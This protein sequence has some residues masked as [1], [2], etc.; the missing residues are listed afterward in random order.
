MSQTLT[1]LASLAQMVEAV[2]AIVIFAYASVVA[3]EFR[4]SIKTRYLDGMKYVR[5]LIATPEAGEK[6]DWVYN[7][8]GNVT[9]PL[10]REDAD[11]VRA[12][13]RDFDFIGLLCRK[14][15]LP[16]EIITETYSRNILEMWDRL[17]PSVEELRQTAH[18][19]YYYLEFEWLALKA[20][21]AR[22]VV[23]RK[24]PADWL[25]DWTEESVIH[26]LI[27]RIAGFKNR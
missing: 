17:R 25:R 13:C 9:R 24:S 22:G 1:D 2:I 3:R 6:R 11:R 5:D 23:A 27:R 20:A 4:E 26:V 12:I 16:T 19:P 8:L 18:D 15:L 21:K 7:E 14:G 10:S